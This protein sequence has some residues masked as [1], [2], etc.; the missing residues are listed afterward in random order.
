MGQNTD[1]SYGKYPEHDGV[2]LAAMDGS[3]RYYF[4]HPAGGIASIPAIDAE[5]AREIIA[6][7]VRGFSPEDFEQVGGFNAETWD[8]PDPVD[9]DRDV[10]E[11][12]LWMLRAAMRKGSRVGHSGKHSPRKN[13][14]EYTI[15][16][17]LDEWNDPSKIP[18][19]DHDA[20]QRADGVGPDRAA[21]VVGAAVANRLIARPIRSET[22]RQGPK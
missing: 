21:Q 14:T 11:H 19:H 8:Y 17:L 6:D 4:R 18:L 1:T 13:P 15:Q 7:R 10:N 5:Q 9:S 16:T 20:L 12:D 3:E 22:S 2:R